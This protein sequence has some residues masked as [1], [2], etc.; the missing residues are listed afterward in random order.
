MCHKCGTKMN[1]TIRVVAYTWKALKN[2]EIPLQLCIT[3]DRKKKFV[4]LGISVLPEHWDFEKNEP[5]RNCPNKEVIQQIILQKTAEYQSQILDYKLV[6]KDFTTTTLIEK[7]NKPLK[8]KTVHELFNIQIERL[9]SAKRLNYALTYKH[10]LSSLLK[11]NKHLD[12]YFSDI[13]ISW[14]KKYENWLRGNDLKP[15]T[16]AVYFRTLRTLYNLAIEEGIVKA[17][18]YPFKAFNVAKLSQ[19]TA[20]RAIC[21]DDINAIINYKADYSVSPYSEIAIDIFTFSYFMG[22]INF[23]DI[24]N[25]TKENIIDNQLSYVRKK[26]K[27][28]IRLPLQPKAVELI[29]KYSNPENPYLFPILDSFHKTEQQKA[30]RVHKVIA[31][32]NKRLKEIGKELN[33]PITLTSYCARHAFCTQLK[34]NG[35]ST[36]IISQILAHSSEKVTQIYLNSFGN[37]TINE[38][39]RKLL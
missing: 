26:T 10:L 9:N 38:A 30:N 18:Y 21:K 34:F 6:N 27:K 22:G 37:E 19:E 11:F 2:N 25:L 23:V 32:V 39:M 29:E 16:I 14:L 31:K 20:K 12:I 24:A 3:K 15:N 1:V 28:L 35:V 33:I 36:S 8:A 4:S 7:V 13:D 17:E 5:K